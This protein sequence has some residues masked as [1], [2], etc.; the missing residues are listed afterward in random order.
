MRA[1]PRTWPSIRASRF[2]QEPLALFCIGVYTHQGY[3]GQDLA[4]A[5]S[6]NEHGPRVHAADLATDPVCGMRINP[7]TAKYRA[8]H[9]GRAYYFCS[10]GCRAKFLANPE[11]YIDAEA[12]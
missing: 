10:A 9:A 4:M 2:R 11:R 7:H 3:I 12:K 1:S 6:V 5:A 8:E